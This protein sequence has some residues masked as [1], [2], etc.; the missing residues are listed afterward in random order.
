MISNK[1]GDLLSQFDN[2]NENEILGG[3]DIKIGDNVY[4]LT[5][6]IYKA[7]SSTSY[8]GKNMKNENDILLI[9]IIMG[10]LGYT[11]VGD[12]PSKRKTFLQNHF[13][14]YLK[15]FKPKHLMKLKTTL[16]I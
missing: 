14:I 10:D 2:I 4:K 13:Q 8:N 6:E 15:I 5:S 16:I 9:K 11:G 7:L 3:D 1:N 12:K